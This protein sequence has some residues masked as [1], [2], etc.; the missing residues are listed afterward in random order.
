MA[1]LEFELTVIEYVAEDA[2]SVSTE[3][4]V[5]PEPVPE[6]EPEEEVVEEPEPEQEIIE[7]EEQNE[8]SDDGEAGDAVAPWIPPW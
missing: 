6:P 7:E 8:T 1:L 3:E 4:E 2:F 5:T